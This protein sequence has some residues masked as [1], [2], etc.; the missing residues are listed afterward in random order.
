MGRKRARSLEGLSFG[1]LERVA[2][3]L[4]EA[5]LRDR[6]A[7]PPNLVERLRRMERHAGG[8][9]Q[10]LQVIA[11]GR[12]LLGDENASAAADRDTVDSAELAERG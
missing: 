8:D 7:V 3:V 5:G 6:A 1:R 4:V 2:T 12:R 10:T 11:S 9:R